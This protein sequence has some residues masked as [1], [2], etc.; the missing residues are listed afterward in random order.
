M[1]MDPIMSELV[2]YKNMPNYEN[3]KKKEEKYNNVTL[4]F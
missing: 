4:K 3:T 1:D 2:P